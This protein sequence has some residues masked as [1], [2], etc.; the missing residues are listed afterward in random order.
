[1]WDS[2]IFGGMFFGLEATIPDGAQGQLLAMP[3]EITPQVQGIMW[4]TGIELGLATCK[5]NT[6]S[7]VISL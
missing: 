5:A 4:D 1:M 2:D 6:L 3:S 7:A